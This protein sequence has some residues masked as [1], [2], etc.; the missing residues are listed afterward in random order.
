MPNSAHLAACALATLLTAGPVAAQTPLS[1]IDWL[2][3]SVRKP[4]TAAKPRRAP[5]TDVAVNALPRQ[6]TVAPLGAP[7]PDRVGLLPAERVGLPDDL[8]HGSASADLARALSHDRAGALPALRDLLRAMLQSAAEPPADSG[9]EA[10]LFFARIDALLAMGD[11]D[12][13]RAL[14]D[15]AEREE[16]RH[17]RRWFDIALLTGHEDLGCARMQALPA[18]TPTYAARVFCLARGGDWAT[19]ALTLD[20]AS[21]L[22][23][24]GPA[25]AALLSAFLDDGTEPAAS[26]IPPRQPSPLQ[27]ALFEAIG[28]PIGTA[29][30]PLAFAH[31]DLR[32]TVGWKAQIEAAERLARAGAISGSQLWSVYG[33]RQAAASGGVWDRVRLAHDLDAAMQA[34]DAGA[35]AD[36]LPDLWDAMRAAGLAHAFAAHYG[37]ALSRLDLDGG[38]AR[39]LAEIGVLSPARDRILATDAANAL[40]PFLL[41]LARSAPDPSAAASDR[42]RAI[43][44][45]FDAPPPARAGEMLQ[46]GRIGEALLMAMDLIETGEAGNPDALHDGLAILRAAGQDDTAR[47]AALDLLILDRRI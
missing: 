28:L 8:W 18:I 19:A 1:A 36:L 41:S 2:S 23:V 20:T 39:T 6:V 12:A 33:A 16:P 15:R 42:E 9:P 29:S 46:T 30:L 4:A 43:A 17:F 31:S 3:D 32:H 22:G 26:L 27:F 10:V 7:A 24:V 44:E 37:P 38:A 21:A 14:L 11:I 5:A 34:G 47:D 25:E 45:G 13:A 35:V 40:P